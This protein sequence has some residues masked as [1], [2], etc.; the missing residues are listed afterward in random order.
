MR[1]RARCAGAREGHFSFARRRGKTCKRCP[2]QHARSCGTASTAVRRST[3]RAP[4]R[5]PRRSTGPRR[6]AGREVAAPHRDRRGLTGRRGRGGHA[7]AAACRSSSAHGEVTTVERAAPNDVAVFRCRR[8]RPASA[9]LC[10]VAEQHGFPG[11]SSSIVAESGIG[12][13]RRRSHCVG[14]TSTSRSAR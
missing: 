7:A 9:M 10:D 14:K 5:I 4:R 11:R 2:R 12:S 13:T 1:S 3:D 6:P 8:D